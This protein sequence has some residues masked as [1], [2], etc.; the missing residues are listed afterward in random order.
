M[1]PVNGSSVDCGL[2]P[3]N[4]LQTGRVLEGRFIL[5][6][7]SP[8]LLALSSSV[9]PL[10]GKKTI[11]LPTLYE[12]SA[13]ALEKDGNMITHCRNKINFILTAMEFNQEIVIERRCL[14]VGI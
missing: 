3:D 14:K 9:C 1:R 8:F 10:H 2:C 11:T 4:D 7:Y 12:K 5:L 13:I 6:D